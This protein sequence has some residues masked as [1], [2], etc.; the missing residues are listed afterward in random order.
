MLAVS[1]PGRDVHAEFE[2]RTSAC[3]LH[4]ANIVAPTATEWR[5]RYVVAGSLSR[6]KAEAVV[7]L[8]HDDESADSARFACADDLVG[9]ETTR[10]EHRWIFVTVAPFPVGVGIEAPMDDSDHFRT[11][12]QA[13]RES[14]ARHR[15]CRKPFQC[16]RH[17][18]GN[19]D[20]LLNTHALHKA[21]IPYPLKTRNQPRNR[22]N[23]A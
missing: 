7:M 9:V 23:S 8:G 14:L 2:P 12:G 11:L 4:L 5:F 10:R 6:P 1:V 19:H 13:S 16:S 22:Q 3:L 15:S 17:N 21:I 20:N 18:K